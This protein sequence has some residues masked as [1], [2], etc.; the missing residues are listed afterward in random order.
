MPK[1]VDLR[2]CGAIFVKP[3]SDSRLGQGEGAFWKFRGDFG[4]QVVA[5]HHGRWSGMAVRR[6]D[7]GFI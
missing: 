7:F 6:S 3:T 1:F 2:L 4:L 5:V